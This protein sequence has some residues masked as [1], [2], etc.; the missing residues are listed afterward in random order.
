MIHDQGLQ[1]YL[2]A[3]A[4]GTAVYVHNRS[5]HRRLGDITPEEAFTGEKL[6]ISHL[7]IFG[8]SVYIHV[9]REKRTKLDPARKQGI[10]VGYS[11]SAKA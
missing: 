4:C 8:C 10:F 5:P 7:R 1:M 2:W 9:P 6:D 11:E 3:K